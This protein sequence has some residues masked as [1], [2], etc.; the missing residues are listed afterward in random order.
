MYQYEDRIKWKHFPRYWP[1]W[2]VTGEFHSQRPV[3]RSFDVFFDLRLNKWLSNPSRRWW[4]E[5]PSRSLWRHCNEELVW[6]S[7]NQI[8]TY[9]H[10]QTIISI[11]QSIW[12][13]HLQNVSRFVQNSTCYLTTI[14]PKTLA[15]PK[16]YGVSNC[17]L[18][19]LFHIAGSAQ[20]QRKHQS[21]AI[22][23]ALWRKSTGHQWILFT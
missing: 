7:S 21:C 19:S 8:M 5:T 10:H 4:L 22:L 23:A 11:R 17:H 14:V 20:Q 3:T 9:R 16:R 1:F 15:S 6:S 2:G 13:C 12:E 18:H